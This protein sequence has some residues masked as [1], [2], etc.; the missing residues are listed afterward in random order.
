[1][2]SNFSGQHRKTRNINLGGRNSGS[3]NSRDSVLKRAQLEREKRERSRREE[4]AAIRIQAFLRS[5]NQIAIAREKS[6]QKWLEDAAAFNSRQYAGL[7]DRELNT[8]LLEFQFFFAKRYTASELNLHEL[9]V[10]LSI[11]TSNQLQ[12]ISS[13]RLQSTLVAVLAALE[14]HLGADGAAACQTK[15]LQISLVLIDHSSEQVVKTLCGYCNDKTSYT[16]EIISLLGENIQALAS[17]F[18]LEY[19]TQF[20]PNPHLHSISPSFVSLP[21]ETVV[22]LIHAVNKTPE[23]QSKSTPLLQVWQLAN[24]ISIIS[25]QTQNRDTLQAVNKIISNLSVCIVSV[26]PR[27]TSKGHDSDNEE[28]YISRRSR[29]QE[30]DQNNTVLF[31]TSDT[32]LLSLISKLYSQSFVVSVMKTLLSD[33][34]QDATF[35]LSSLFVALGRLFPAKKQDISLYVSLVS[36]SDGPGSMSATAAL[37]SSFKRSDFY[38]QGCDHILSGREIAQI[39]I[40]QQNI[41]SQFVFILELISYWLIITDDSEFHSNNSNGGLTL[42]EIKNVSLLLK[43]LAYTFIW[44]WPEIGT[45]TTL[46]NSFLTFEKIK[47]ITILVLRQIYIRD[48]R[49]K[50]LGDGF[51]LMTKNFD[52]EMFIPVVVEE[53]ERRRQAELTLQAAETEE[54][55]EDDHAKRIFEAKKSIL[56]A[57]PVSMRLEML[58]KAPQFMPFDVRLRIFQAF[59]SRDR[60]RHYNE[61]M[62]SSYMNDF[63]QL[64]KHRGDI[65]RD[66]LLQDA[67]E[68]FDKLGSDFK[69]PIGVTFYN[70]YG[71]EMG[72]DGGGI[73][74][75]FLTS[76]CREAFQPSPD[77][78]YDFSNTK[79][80]LF[81][82][83][84][85]QLLFPNPIFGVSANY[86]ELESVERREGLNY[87]RFLGKIIGKCLSEEILVD[88]EFALFFL[89][90]LTGMIRNSF[91]DMYS[92]DPEVYN[93]LVKVHNYPGDVEADLSLDFT[94]T[95]SVGHGKQATIPLVENGA[96]RM[97][98]NSNRLEY[99][100]AVA[101][102][103]LNAVLQAQTS[104]FL[105]GLSEMINLNWLTMFNGSEL[106]MLISGGF[107]KI[108]LSD[109]KAHCV[110]FG[111]TNEE[112]TMVH[113]WEVLEEF[114]EEDKA[115]FIKFVTSVPK[116][117]LLGFSVLRP[118]FA[119]RHAGFD[120]SRLPT[121]STCVNMIKLPDYRSKSILREKLLASIRADAGFDLS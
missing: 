88:V 47:D 14:R 95:Q 109:L 46:Q 24:F 6:E 121:A 80:G 7:S 100:H 82:V 93:S 74:K 44:N 50:F 102:Y 101:N 33:D 113:F 81:S 105:R 75:E 45:L 90:K 43:N 104:A 38:K 62:S 9:S 73:S 79:H 56:S 11:L 107:A 29:E 26:K 2:F 16:P 28:D 31:K 97:V 5:R 35:V 10:V 51:W 117:P 58:R 61:N 39:S 19:F 18:P 53:E 65:R 71:P 4:T 63:G 108:D 114:D 111:F 98:S 66:F 91:D 110:L 103:K 86:S 69:S 78:E 92:L 60:E 49:R 41:L 59:V 52:M 40:S 115:R 27:D 67:Y 112:P 22:R 42:E 8:S 23:A 36:S 12:H 85:D 118:K 3:A 64:S 83:N 21:Q 17:K 32:F 68:S 119:I 48:S 15:A 106:Q 55:P 89:Q 87:I 72:I 70:E 25:S 116:A 13:A 99:I 30:L 1:M 84:K 57:G 37:W 120:K 34:D 54:D 20:L 96:Q 94:V 76:I 77:D